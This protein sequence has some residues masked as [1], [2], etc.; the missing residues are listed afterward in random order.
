MC[1]AGFDL[2]ACDLWQDFV[3]PSQKLE[4][5]ILQQNLKYEKK[6]NCI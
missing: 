3:F 5:L 6:K 2:T 1:N 4:K